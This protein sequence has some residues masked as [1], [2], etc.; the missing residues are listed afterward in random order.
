MTPASSQKGW[1][2]VPTQAVTLEGWLSDLASGSPTPGGGGAS[3]LT[4]AASAALISMVC[5]LTI[6]KPKYAAHEQKLTGIRQEAAELRTEALHLADADARAFGAV[7]AAYKLGKG[8]AAEAEVR[9]RAIQA[10]LLDAAGVPLRTAELAADLIKLAGDVLDRANQAVLSDV[11]VAAATARA[12]LDSAAI[13]VEV[14]L[15]G[16][17]DEGQRSRLAAELSRFAAAAPDAD[18]IVHEVRARIRR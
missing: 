3:A 9:G 10:A 14:N 18:A 4:A 17:S 15:A 5:N 1:A 2:R 8:T 6:G 13:N 16:I 11:A 7:L 12:A